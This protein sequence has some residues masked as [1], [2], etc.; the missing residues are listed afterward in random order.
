M[1]TVELVGGITTVA[2]E[3]LAEAL[4]HAVEKRAQALVIRLDTPGGLL[5]ATREIVASFLKSDLPI[6]GV[7]GRERR[8]SRL[9]GGLYHHGGAR[10]G[11]GARDQYR[12][13]DTRLCL[14]WRH[15]GG[16]GE[17]GD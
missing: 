6:C 5:S 15:R 11:D 14:R 17:E 10:R 12:R 13:R 7:G 4:E 16:H 9:C 1:I 3:F 2:K 8:A